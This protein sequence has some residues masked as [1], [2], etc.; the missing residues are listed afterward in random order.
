L[1]AFNNYDI[2]CVTESWAS[3]CISNSELKIEGYTMYRR[4]R[5]SVR[6]NKGGGVLINVKEVYNTSENNTLNSVKCEAL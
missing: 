3:P 6:D 4:D 2:I 5:S 1:V